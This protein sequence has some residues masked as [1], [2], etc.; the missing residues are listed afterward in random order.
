M[1]NI[2]Y[3]CRRQVSDANNIKGSIRMRSKIQIILA[4]AAAA[5]LLFCVGAGCSDDDGGTS[6]SSVPQTTSQEQSKA[7]S[8]VQ[9][10]T[11]SNTESK[12]ESSEES[13]E[14]SKAESS[15]ES[16][17]E[18]S[19]AEE[20]IDYEL[21][22]GNWE[23]EEGGTYQG[24]SIYPDG[25]AMYTFSSNNSALA[26]WEIKGS[27]VYLYT[28]GGASEYLEYR[29]EKLLDNDGGREFNK[30]EYLKYDKNKQTEDS[31]NSEDSE[32]SEYPT[33]TSG[34][35]GSW[36][37]SEGGL[38][39]AFIIYEGG[40]VLYKYADGSSAEAYWNVADGVLYIYIADTYERFTLEDGS[41]YDLDKGCYYQKVDTLYV[42]R[43]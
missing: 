18:S 41:L 27:K 3:G 19:E 43:Y 5:L 42:D 9:S 20:N 40:S 24:L 13:K 39:Q 6:A 30:V 37:Y 14:E 16:A 34:V 15:E 35:V 11:E 1:Y 25:S 29:D 38:Y 8:S 28:Y 21:V 23:Y 4:A 10:S 7:E 22:L 26:T 17:E 12:A 36:E 2:V 33:D 32:D 31:E